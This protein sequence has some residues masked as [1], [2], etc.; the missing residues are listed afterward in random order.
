MIPSGSAPE[1]LCILTRKKN[2]SDKTILKFQ[3]L[4]SNGGGGG[5]D[6]G[7]AGEKL[8]DHSKDKGTLERKARKL[9]WAKKGKKS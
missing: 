2:F 3:T 4:V 6:T 8:G 1:R 9:T 7:G 5:G